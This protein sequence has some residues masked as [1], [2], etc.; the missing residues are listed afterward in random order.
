MK[1]YA[2]Y[3]IETEKDS[4]AH[5]SLDDTKAVK[6]DETSIMEI[7]EQGD[8]LLLEL[9]DGNLFFNVSEPLS[10]EE[11][12]RIKTSNA[13]MGIRGT[14]GYIVNKD[15]DRSAVYLLSGKAEI[16]ATSPVTGEEKNG[17]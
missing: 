12:F 11:T 16:T 6:L 1:L 9:K 7:V 10:E 14:S 3:F 8:N 4:T 13:I 5:I 17:N 2:G 15:K